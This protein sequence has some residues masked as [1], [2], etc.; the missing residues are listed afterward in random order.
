[1]K[2]R[3]PLPALRGWKL[4]LTVLV[5]AVV[6]GWS[7]LIGPSH[8]DFE[9]RIA[10][11]NHVVMYS[12]IRCPKCWAMKAQF[13]AAGIDYEEVRIDKEG[14]EVDAFRE[15]LRAN[16]V[17]TDVI[18]TPTVLVNDVLLLNAP[19]FEEVTAQLRMLEQ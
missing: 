1:M 4:D 10:D 19:D 14:P 2:N 11:D 17:L 16:N 3:F 6:I 12:M 8:P 18:G 15:M 5:V 7:W 13:A 9:G